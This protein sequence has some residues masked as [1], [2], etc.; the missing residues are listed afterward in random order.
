[1]VFRV[2]VLR[3]SQLPNEISQIEDCEFVVFKQSG[4]RL[5]FLD[6]PPL[7]SYFESR[8]DLVVMFLGG[9]DVIEYIHNPL[10]L[11]QR[12][13]NR[14]FQIRNN[15]NHV[16]FVNLESRDYEVRSRPR[17]RITNEQYA[18]VSRVVNRSLKKFCAKNKMRFITT[19]NIRFQ[20]LVRQDGIHF[21]AQAIQ[22]LV[23]KIHNL[24]LKT[25]DG[26]PE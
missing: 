23:Q 18:E 11:A 16:A 1:M 3:H 17:Y 8:F 10:T 5:D 25:R 9:N 15:A 22:L 19:R 4:A 6:Y 7:S 26:L 14:L 20:G 2:A 21:N 12:I 13:K 24:A